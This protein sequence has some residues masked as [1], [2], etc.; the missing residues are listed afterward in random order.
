MQRLITDEKLKR[1]E[2]ENS[3]LFIKQLNKDLEAK[4]FNIEQENIN[5]KNSLNDINDK[6]PELEF[7]KVKIENLIK[8]LE[9]KDSIIQ[10]FENILKEN[11]SKKIIK[12]NFILFYLI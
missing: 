10:Y 9:Y 8:E 6:I 3:M 5:L 2:I 4:I 1:E 7:Q 12:K 11:R